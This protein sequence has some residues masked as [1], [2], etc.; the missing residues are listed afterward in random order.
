MK[1]FFEIQNNNK[2]LIKSSK[3]TLI[4]RTKE[5]FKIFFYSINKEINELLIP[6]LINFDYISWI[7]KLIEFNKDCFDNKK[8]KDFLTNKEFFLLKE[9]NFDFTKIS[10]FFSVF[11]FKG[12]EVSEY[13]KKFL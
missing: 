7:K 5:D 10:E 12:N 4:I 9:K 2:I 13:F 8:L 11:F 1:V 6:K 3:G